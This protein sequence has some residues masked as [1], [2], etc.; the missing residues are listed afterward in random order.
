SMTKNAVPSTCGSSS[1]QRTRG[2]GTPAAD[3]ASSSAN[4]WRRLDSITCPGG[5]RRSTNRSTP[6]RKAHVSR[7]APPGMRRSS[8]SA[9]ACASRR[10]RYAVSRSLSSGGVIEV[11]RPAVADT[12]PPAP[13]REPLCDPG[14]HALAAV[15]QRHHGEDAALHLYRGAAVGGMQPR[16]Q[17]RVQPL[18]ASV[19]AFH[20]DP[21]QR[22]IGT[23]FR[24]HAA[25]LA[26]AP[27]T[28]VRRRRRD[29]VMGAEVHREPAV[30]LGP[31]PVARAPRAIA[32]P[33][34]VDGDRVAADRQLATCSAVL[35][36]VAAR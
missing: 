17:P 22:A 4:S 20:L 27:V 23:P 34:A 1:H 35:L 28:L 11:L 3:A 21:G 32:E 9:T 8:S 2:T 31:L 25:P 12:I 5:S 18:G 7:D 26:P 19:L 24:V 13:F 33:E 6:M 10:P 14:R 30:P 15:P 29:P 36:Q 16:A